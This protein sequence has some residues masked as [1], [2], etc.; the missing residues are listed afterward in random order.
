M[1]EPF[2]E[3]KNKLTVIIR[4]SF[5]LS[6]DISLISTKAKNIANFLL[7]KTSLSSLAAMFF[8]AKNFAEPQ[9]FRAIEFS[10]NTFPC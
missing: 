6:V 1:F 2:G 5:N 8:N 3:Y 10:V 7:L 4:S 9:V